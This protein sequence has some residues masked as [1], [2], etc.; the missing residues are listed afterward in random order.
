MQW[1]TDILANSQVKVTELAT[2]ISTITESDG[3]VRKYHFMQVTNLKPNT[4]YKLQALAISQDLGRTFSEEIEF[5]T[6]L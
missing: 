1:N 4:R 6:D 2:G 3:V 5:T